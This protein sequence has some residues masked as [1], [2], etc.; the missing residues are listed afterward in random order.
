MEM[1]QATTGICLQWAM[2]YIS[3]R[4]QSPGAAGLPVSVVFTALS[5][6][7]PCWHELSYG[8]GLPRGTALFHCPL[9][10]PMNLDKLASP[11]AFPVP[12][13]GI[14]ASLLVAVDLLGKGPML[15]SPQQPSLNSVEGICNDGAGRSRPVFIRTKIQKKKEKK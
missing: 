10:P 4:K 6:A 11:M 1:I 8:P 12:N 14:L 3:E 5:G 7:W 15:S 2:A 13:S 9:F